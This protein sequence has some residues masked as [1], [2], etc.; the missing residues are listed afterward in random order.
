[1][2]SAEPVQ[3]RAGGGNIRIGSKTFIP[4]ML[5]WNRGN[6][7]LTL[8]E[9]IVAPTGS[10]DSSDL[11]NPGLNY[12]TFDTDFTVTYLNPETGQDYSIIIGYNYNTE[13]SDTD[14]QTGEEVHID[15]MINQF[16]S[17]SL[18]IGSHGFY[19]EQVSGDS[20]RK[21]AAGAVLLSKYST[22]GL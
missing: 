16:F 3:I 9:Y 14:Y 20:R 5:F 18:A 1:M 11:A 6:F 10:H 4:A 22:H 21:S 2:R 8:A 17:E 12:W 15:Y 13:N 7:H 19:L